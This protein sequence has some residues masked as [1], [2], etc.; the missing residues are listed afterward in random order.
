MNIKRLKQIIEY[1]YIFVYL[2]YTKAE[3]YTYINQQC[4]I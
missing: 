3:A 4:I 1:I 2:N